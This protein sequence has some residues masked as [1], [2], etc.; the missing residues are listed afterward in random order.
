M[1]ARGGC[2]GRLHSLLHLR[3]RATR[4]GREEDRLSPPRRLVWTS[5]SVRCAFHAQR[6]QTSRRARR[7]PCGGV[8]EP[9]AR[10]LLVRERRDERLGASARSQAA[11]FLLADIPHMTVLFEPPPDD[12]GR[13]PGPGPVEPF[14]RREMTP[15]SARRAAKVPAAG[16]KGDKSPVDFPVRPAGTFMLPSRESAARVASRSAAGCPRTDGAGWQLRP[17]GMRCTGRG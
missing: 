12:S 5:T 6:R 1:K 10:L 16:T 17:F 2:S 7:T 8:S 11:I 15:A 14:V 9:R 4:A 13:F 3:A